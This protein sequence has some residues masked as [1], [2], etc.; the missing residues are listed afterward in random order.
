M[1]LFLDSTER[2][3]PSR[4][5]KHRAQKLFDILLWFEIM[6]LKSKRNVFA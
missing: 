2:L 6:K 5:V 3:I 1:M 4:Q